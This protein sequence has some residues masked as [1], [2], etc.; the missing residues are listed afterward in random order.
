MLV[1][2]RKLDESLVINNNI[3]IKIIEIEENRIK[4]GIE[5]PRDIPVHRTEV[6][7]K[8]KNINKAKSNFTK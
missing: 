1:F 4:I 5:A 7:N 2:T 8:I 3:I 6:F